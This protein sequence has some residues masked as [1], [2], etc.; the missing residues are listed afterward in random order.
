LARIAAAVLIGVLAGAAPASSQNRLLNPSFDTDLAGWTPEIFDSSTIDWDPMDVDASPASGSARFVKLTTDGPNSVR[1]KQCVLVTPEEP[2]ELRA[3]VFLPA[4]ATVGSAFLSG[5]WFPGDACLGT[6]L[7]SESESRSAPTGEWFA[8]EWPASVV[9]PPG[10]GSLR[11]LAGALSTDAS[12]G[13]TVYADQVYAP[14]PSAGLA[15]TAA[16]AAL[17]ALRRRRRSRSSIEPEGS[18]CRATSSC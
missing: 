3:E 9:A 6:D 12:G 4:Q 11:V 15:R 17:A 2:I 5:S 13:Y 1:L 8:I 7:G 16:L 18:P 10:S 14:E